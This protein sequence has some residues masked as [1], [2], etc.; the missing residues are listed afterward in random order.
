MGMFVLKWAHARIAQVGGP[1]S[2]F[3]HISVPCL[4]VFLLW[5]P[6][7]SRTRDTG[8]ASFSIDLDK[9]FNEVVAIVDEVAHSGLIK[10]T[11]EYRGE[12]QLTGAQ[13]SEKSQLFPAWT[14]PGKV[15]YKVR[16]KALSPSHFLNSNDVGT[17]AVR[18][19]VQ[20]RGPNLTRLFIDAVFIENARH[21]GHPSDGY[22][23]TCEFGEIGKLLKDREQLQKLAASGQPF[24]PG[25]ESTSHSQEQQ[26]EIKAEAQKGAA[27]NQP[28][29]KEIVPA[30]TPRVVEVDSAKLGDLQRVIAEQKSLLATDQANLDKLEAQARQLRASEFVRVKSDRAE[31]KVLPYAHARVVEALKKGQEVTVLAKS[32][33]WY[34]VRSEDGQEGWISHVLLEVQP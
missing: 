20:E 6:G 21:H 11:F 17:V 27:R 9:P 7:Y 28:K 18:Y 15:F 16:S 23:E 31:L 34:Q 19:V 25:Q 33:Y 22:V 32:T 2:K 8:A 24:S 1:N 10:G 3:R 4:L 5:A 30:E 26:D 13:F 12:E 29:P 14:Q